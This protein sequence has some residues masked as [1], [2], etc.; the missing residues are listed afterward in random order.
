M[1][2]GSE[3]HHD[4]PSHR[5]A[6]SLR[7]SGRGAGRVWRAG[8]LV[9]FYVLLFWAG[10]IHLPRPWCGTLFIVVV[11]LMVLAILLL[12]A[13]QT[14]REAARSYQCLN[15]MKQLLLA[16]HNYH[17]INGRFPPPYATGDDGEALY[18]WRVLIL[19]LIEDNFYFKQFRRN[20]PWDGTNNSKLV[21]S[22]WEFECP[23]HGTTS[24]TNYFTIVGPQTA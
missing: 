5:A 11:V 12:P 24:E 18:S 21:V 1:L 10:V 7:P 13:V 4:L 22:I 9:S 17:D 20:E 14:A 15:N 23:T 19:P 3:R 6:V 16:V 2:I 8:I